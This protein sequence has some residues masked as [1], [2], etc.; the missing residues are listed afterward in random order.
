MYLY[1]C[2][3]DYELRMAGAIFYSSLCLRAWHRAI[4]QQP[5][6]APGLS[7][8][9]AQLLQPHFLLSFPRVSDTPASLAFRRLPCLLWGCLLCMEYFPFSTGK[10]LFVLYDATSSVTAFSTLLPLTKLPNESSQVSQCTKLISYLT[11]KKSSEMI[12]KEKNISPHVELHALSIFLQN[13]QFVFSRLLGLDV[14]GTDATNRKAV[15]AP[16]I[17]NTCYLRARLQTLGFW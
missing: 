9:T 10:I 2:L 17:E 12:K 5:D 16:V 6:N 3:P 7:E 15:Q 11:T 14:G 13:P 8:E 1:I 4:T